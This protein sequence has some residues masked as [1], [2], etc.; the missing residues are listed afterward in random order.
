MEPFCRLGRPVPTPPPLDGAKM[1][2]LKKRPQ[3][4][5]RG[6]EGEVDP[7]NTS[8]RPSGPAVRPRIK[9]AQSAKLATGRT[10]QAPTLRRS[11]FDPHLD[12]LKVVLTNDTNHR[13]HFYWL[14][15]KGVPQ[16]RGTTDP[17]GVWIQQTNAE[18]PFLITRDVEAAESSSIPPL[19]KQASKK[20]RENVTPTPHG[21]EVNPKAVS[22]EKEIALLLFTG[23]TSMLLT[24]VL[25]SLLSRGERQDGYLNQ[26]HDYNNMSAGMPLNEALDICRSNLD[27]VLGYCV[28]NLN[29]NWAWVK[30]RG[31]RV[32]N[33]FFTPSK[34]WTTVTFPRHLCCGGTPQ[35]RSRKRHNIFE[36]NDQVEFSDGG[37]T[38]SH[39]AAVHWQDKVDAE[40]GQ[41]EPIL[42][43][44]KTYLPCKIHGMQLFVEDGCFEKHPLMQELLVN[45]LAEMKRILP[46]KVWAILT[47][48][49]ALWINDTLQYLN[50]EKP[51]CGL[52]CHMG[53]FMTTNGRGDTPLKARCVEICRAQDYCDWHTGQPAML[54]HEFAHAFHALSPGPH[55][56][57]EGS[58]ND[59]I[60]AQAYDAAMASG[61]YDSGERFGN[62]QGTLGYEELGSK[63]YAAANRFEYFAECS[64]A[65]WSSRRFHND[66]FPYVHAE[67]KGF[68]P[69]GYGMCEKVWGVEGNKVKS[70]VEVPVGWL[71]AYAKVREE[72]I[73]AAFEEA[74]RDKNGTL[75]V[76]EF[77]SCLYQIGHNQCTKNRNT[78]EQGKGDDDD[79]NRSNTSSSG[80]NSSGSGVP[81]M[82]SPEEVASIVAFAD[83]NNDGVVSYAEF[84]VWL[85]SVLGARVKEPEEEGSMVLP[86]R[87]LVLPSFIDSDDDDLDG[88][89][90][91]GV[92]TTAESLN[93]KGG[94]AHASE[95]RPHSGKRGKDDDGRGG[96]G[97]LAEAT[98]LSDDTLEGDAQ[99]GAEKVSSEVEMLGPLGVNL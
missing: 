40:S 81:W 22:G 90:R 93:H 96:D 60:I 75:D 65:F 92:A 20:R 38:D 99:D 54:L 8:D 66:Y 97:D 29:P 89:L 82:P 55:G 11:A 51:Q 36:A 34:E 87:L 53:L 45:D 94:G 78:E 59:Q 63:P 27:I 85:T 95:T 86:P 77:S 69:I 48:L 7:A 68:D 25:A 13:V 70:R 4:R 46:R 83:A 19:K 91:D 23:H 76:D 12:G 41:G 58:E 37:L 84:A 2:L 28:H 79:N 50:G 15:Y 14:D 88:V 73:I 32:N 39:A 72:D 35:E 18:H 3:H 67:L 47:Q 17:G 43:I 5:P 10:I 64:E 24:A 44:G 57:F 56:F 42:S 52:W 49:S 74:D 9:R 98:G 62:T 61:K 26:G 80:N 30:L 33:S 71:D 6:A 16:F 1:D 21:T 31:S